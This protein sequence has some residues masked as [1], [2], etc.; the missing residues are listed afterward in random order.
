MRMGGG[1]HV[2]VVQVGEF[3]GF[4][5]VGVG[6]SGGGGGGGGGLNKGANVRGIEGEQRGKR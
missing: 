5:R 1:V 3:R 4:S 6:S 2:R